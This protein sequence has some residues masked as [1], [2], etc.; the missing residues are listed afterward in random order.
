MAG[1]FMKN[2]SCASRAGC[3]CGWIRVSK[4]QKPLS[5]KLLVGISAKPSCRKISRNCCR[6]FSSGCTWPPAGGAPAP[7]TRLY[8]LNSSFLH[9]PSAIISL[10]RSA[11]ALTRS[12][13]NLAPL[14]IEY[15]FHASC[16]TSFRFFTRFS[17][18]FAGISVP[19]ATAARSATAVSSMASTLR[20]TRG[21]APLTMPSHLTCMACLNPTSPT[22]TSTAA[23][24][25]A[26]VHPSAGTAAKACASGDPAVRYVSASGVS[27]SWLWSVA[28]EATSSL[29]SRLF[30][31]PITFLWST[32]QVAAK[33]SDCTA[34]ACD[35][36]SSSAFSRL[37][38]S[39]VAWGGWRLLFPHAFTCG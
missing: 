2:V 36:S 35:T 11:W 12:R 32:P 16:L 30:I 15:D 29:A 24:N 25:S 10:V 38:S 28:V 9:D 5:M 13:A 8:A 17:S 6:T 27:T 23:L 34:P 18:S 7:G 4:F 14:A 19:A 20:S 39:M 33:A 22:V 3:I 1:V 21:S 37:A 31:R 26:S